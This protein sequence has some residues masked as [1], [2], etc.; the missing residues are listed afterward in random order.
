MLPL[1]SVP[2]ELML[3]LMIMFSSGSF[4]MT[5]C[6][7]SRDNADRD[8][9]DEVLT[10]DRAVRTPCGSLCQHLDIGT[11]IDGCSGHSSHRREDACEKTC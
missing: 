8:A 6:R 5:G 1:T 7:M 4:E 3:A 9:A 2:S 11:T 10:V